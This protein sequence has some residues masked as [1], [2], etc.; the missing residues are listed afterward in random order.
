[1]RHVLVG[2]L[3]LASAAHAETWQQVAE[4]PARGSVMLLDTEAITGRGQ[5][6]NARFKLVYDSDQPIPA[7][8]RGK[9]PNVDSFRW[10]MKQLQ[11]NCAARTDAI[12]DSFLHSADNQ[13]VAGIAMPPSALRFSAVS[14]GT[15][16]EKMFDAVCS[17]Q[18]V[19]EVTEDSAMQVTSAANPMDYYPPDSMQRKEQ[20]TP[21]V[22]ACVGP[23]GQLLREPIVVGSSGFPELDAAAIKIAKATRYSPGTKKGKPKRESCIKFKVKFVLKD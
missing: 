5:I 17:S 6:R 12:V 9:L 8:Y 18:D 3:L 15:V 10:E 1:M 7:G 11:Y 23:D 4:I 22:Q 21:I 13:V 20:G 16:W 19:R 2:L 14:Q